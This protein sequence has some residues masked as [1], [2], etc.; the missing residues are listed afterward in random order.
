MSFYLAAVLQALCLGP[1]VLGVYLTMKVFR[2]PDITADGSYTL[3]AVVTAIGLVNGWSLWWCIP[4]VVLS[5]AIAG[6]CSAW[7]HNRIKVNLL[8]AGIL[9]MTALY[10]VNLSILG[11]SNVPLLQY[12][13]LFN[14]L[15]VFRT[16]DS[17]TLIIVTCIL[18]LLI[19]FMTYLLRTDFG[20]AMRATG[21][22]EQMLRALGV[23]T[24]RM[25][26][27]GLAIANGLVALSGSLIAQFQGFAD[28]NMGI[29][30]MITGLG[31]VMIAESVVLLFGIKRIAF[32][33]LA[34]ISGMVLFQL[35]LAFSLS[36]GINPVMLKL[37]TALIVLLAVSIPQLRVYGKRF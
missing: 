33:L 37:V 15:T 1:L 18:C 26:W 10:S 19:S 30:V 27:I 22:N 17:N 13:T 7:I 35:I 12:G 36:L 16:S 11:R 31:S 34:V 21:D 24:A 20:L 23:N 6:I 29:G 14:W 4:L 3:G 8:L 2:F 5:G 28:V 9:V 25:K 32:V